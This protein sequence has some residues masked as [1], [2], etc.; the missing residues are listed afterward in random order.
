[1]IP[2]TLGTGLSLGTLLIPQT[3]V[4]PWTRLILQ[5]WVI[6]RTLV[7]PPT[8][9]TLA[10]PQSPMTWAILSNLLIPE[11]LQRSFTRFVF[12]VRKILGVLERLDS[13]KKTSCH[14]FVFCLGIVGTFCNSICGE[15]WDVD[16]TTRDRRVR[17]TH[18]HGNVGVRSRGRRVKATEESPNFTSTHSDVIVRFWFYVS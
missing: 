16:V 3:P 5:T 1:M 10:C 18:S 14:T 9:G 15:M 4:M 2:K 8:L 17:H 12:G 7:D 11:T 6:L 13:A